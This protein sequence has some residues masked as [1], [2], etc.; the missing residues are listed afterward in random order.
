MRLRT[1]IVCF[2]PANIYLFKLNNKNTRTPPAVFIFKFE[3]ISHLILV[4]LLVTL[5]FVWNKMFWI[6]RDKTVLIIRESK[7]AFFRF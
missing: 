5:S 2:N 7:L 6:F 4:F 1:F 3:H